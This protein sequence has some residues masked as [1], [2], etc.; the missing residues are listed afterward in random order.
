MRFNW[1]ILLK[2]QNDVVADIEAL[3]AD[4]DTIGSTEQL[5]NFVAGL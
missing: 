4:V 2:I 3:V 1:W 5:G